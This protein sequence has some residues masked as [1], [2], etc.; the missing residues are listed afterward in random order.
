MPTLAELLAGAQATVQAKAKIDTAKERIKKAR[1][2]IERDAAVADTVALQATL[3]WRPV[4]LVY[5]QENWTCACLNHGET[6][7]G[8]FILYEHARMAN[9]TRLARPRHESEDRNDLPKRV[10]TE[11][12]VVAFCANCAPAEGFTRPYVPPVTIAGRR[13]I[14]LSAE[15]RVYSTE[16][17]NLTSPETDNESFTSDDS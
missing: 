5:R 13:P 11:T 17:A 12:R 3:D 1:S 7:D 9:S 16:W 6:P 4:A 14:T 8:L 15:Q 10:L 2:P